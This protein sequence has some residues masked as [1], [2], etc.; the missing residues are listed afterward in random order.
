MATVQLSD[1]IDV[2]VYQDLPPVNGVEKTAFWESGIVVRSG[3]FDN[4]A[5]SPGKIS[6]MPFWND[7]AESDAP[8]L[9]SDDPTSSATPKNVDQGEQIAR[10]AFLNQ[11]WSASDLAVELAMGDNAMSHIRNRVDRYWSRQWQR[12][13]IASTNGILADNKA[14]YDSDMV[15][16]VAIE[17]GDNATAANLFSRS[18]FT[19]AAFT[20]GDMFDVMTTFAVHSVVY[21]RMVDNDDIDYIP[22]SAGALTIPT[23]M[24]RRVVLDDT[25]PVEAGGT[26]GYKYTSVLF[27]AG[28]FGY[29]EGMPVTPVEVNREAAQGDGAGIETLWTRKAW[30]LHPFGFQATGTPSADSF[31]IAELSAAAAWDRVIARKNIPMA[32][33]ITNG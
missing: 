15:N 26:S 25:M 21:K 24:G 13:L 19:T 29:G 27:G 31:S 14:N 23:F 10:K 22:D 3:L 16:D 8:N 30:L 5:N 1:I 6:E 12:R 2:T 7:L 18:A 20:L 4:L 11:G 9:S 32:F 33:L 28:A 17:D